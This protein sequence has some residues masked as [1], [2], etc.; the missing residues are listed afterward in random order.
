MVQRFSSGL[1]YYVKAKGFLSKG[2]FK[3]ENFN[4][5]LVIHIQLFM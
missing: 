1:K 2:Q 3:L 4:L 5:A